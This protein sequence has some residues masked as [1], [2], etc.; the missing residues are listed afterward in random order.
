M[1]TIFTHLDSDGICSATLIKMTPEFK[2]SRI[3]FTHPTDLA[4]D[5][6]KIQDDL[7][8]C[9]IALDFNS[10]EEIYDI[11]EHHYKNYVITYIDHHI[12]PGPLPPNVNLVHNEE[13]SAT[14][15]VY[16]FYYA[17]LP[18]KAEYI[19]LLGAICDYL[20]ESP[21]MQGL[22]LHFE[23]RTLYLDA[24]IL[25]QGI[26]PY[27]NGPDYE[28]LRHLV[29]ILSQGSYPCEIKEL[30][31][32]ALEITRKDKSFRKFIL[33]SYLKLENIAYI[34]DPPSGSKS[35]IAHWIMGHAETLLGISIVN[36]H[37]NK[38]KADL[39]IRGRY[40]FDLRVIIP[41]IAKA[42]GGSAGGHYNAIG[43]RIPKRNLHD[44][45]KN[46]DDK[47]RELNIQ[48]PF[49]IQD[50]IQLE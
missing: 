42:H 27:G 2:N 21:L 6:K 33:R 1:T 30:T 41:E 46:L 29:K 20:D 44:F 3:I 40:L 35:K 50:L 45:L 28:N 7:I 48:N 13:V 17:L 14:E 9:D 31:R 5:L 26:K 18:R 25:A 47:I 19:A 38:K 22:M 16:R 4:Y 32:N 43:C 15:I 36:M 39:T 23:R 8:I 37:T 12:L 24:G 10:Y 11:F 34:M 49:K